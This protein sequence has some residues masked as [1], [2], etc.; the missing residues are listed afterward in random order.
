MH[1]QFKVFRG[2]VKAR[3]EKLEALTAGV[4]PVLDY[5][6]FAPPEGAMLLLGNL[7][8]RTIMDRCRT[9]WVDFKVFTRSATQGGIIHALWWCGHIILR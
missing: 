7:P 1:T 8:P 9:M 5:V 6:G 2:Q 4:K 3:D